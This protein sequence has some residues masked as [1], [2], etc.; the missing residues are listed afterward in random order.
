MT[1]RKFLPSLSSLVDFL[2][3]HQMKEWKIPEN[4]AAYEKEIAEIMHD[5]DLELTENGK[6]V[7]LTAEIIRDIVV[8]AHANSHIWFNEENQRKGVSGPNNLELSHSINALRNT[9]KNRLEQRV[10]GSKFDLKVDNIG[11]HPNWVPS[12]WV[13][14]FKKTEEKLEKDSPKNHSER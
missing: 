1:N 4:R 11:A 10:G 9:A 12:G 2:T 14:E 7:P 3:I 13:K 5:I 6:V 8:L